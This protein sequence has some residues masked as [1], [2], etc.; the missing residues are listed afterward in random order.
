MNDWP[1]LVNTLPQYNVAAALEAGM[2]TPDVL[3]LSTISQA[4][5]EEMFASDEWDVISN[6]GM[7]IRRMSGLDVTKKV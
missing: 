3:F 1:D 6:T 5:R 2:M 4:K 7:A